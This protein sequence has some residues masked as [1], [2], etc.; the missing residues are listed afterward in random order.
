MI[1]RVSTYSLK[2]LFFDS[3]NLIRKSSS[4]KSHHSKSQT[5]RQRERVCNIR[6]VD[7]ISSFCILEYLEIARVAH[8]LTHTSTQ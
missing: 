8:V 3:D 7:M 6:W 1:E 5:Q 2:S 4:G